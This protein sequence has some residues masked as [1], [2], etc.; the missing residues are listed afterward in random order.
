MTQAWQRRESDIATKV[1]WRT[2]TR[3]HFTQPSGFEIDFDTIGSVG[4]H[5]AAVIALTADNKVIIA[6]QFRAG[7][8]QVMQELPGGMI[9]SGEDP[10]EAAQRELLEETGYSTDN[11]IALGAYHGDAYSNN[12]H[13]YFLARDCKKTADQM[14]EEGED[15]TVRVISISE[16][17][18]NA[19][20]AQ[21]TDAVAVLY[22]YE[23]LKQLTVQK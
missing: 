11:I 14:L 21:M 17:I 18:K 16:L 15:V 5:S 2:V 3:K 1:G 4:D 22:A 23:E 19:Q 13:W 20:T 12:T 7:P 9:D 8:E 10:V 6:E